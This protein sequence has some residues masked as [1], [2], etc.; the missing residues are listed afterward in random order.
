M[1]CASNVLT[2]FPRTAVSASECPG[3]PGIGPGWMWRTWSR[4]GQAARAVTLAP[5]WSW[6]TALY[7]LDTMAHHAVPFTVLKLDAS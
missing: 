4:K 3:H 2:D 7:P 5:C 6:I 1:A